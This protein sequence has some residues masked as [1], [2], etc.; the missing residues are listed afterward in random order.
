MLEG[1]KRLFSFIKMKLNY[2]QTRA[3]AD[4]G[5][6]D[7]KLVI[8]NKKGVVLK[9]PLKKWDH[10]Q[11]EIRSRCLEVQQRPSHAHMGSP[12]QIYQHPSSSLLRRPVGKR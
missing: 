6:T 7:H 3:L 10:P 2:D 4:L 8:K 1:V 5:G 11:K 9:T 12:L